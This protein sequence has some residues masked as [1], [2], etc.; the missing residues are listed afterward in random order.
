MASETR[1][2]SFGITIIVPTLTPIHATVRI[3]HGE[4]PKKFNG[5]EFRR[6]QQKML[7]YIT[8]LNLARFIRKDALLLTKNE[9]DQQMV[10]VVE[11]WKHVDFL[12]RNYILNR[13]DNT[14]YN[15]YSPLKMA[16]ELWESF[17]K[18][19]K[20]EDAGMKKFIVGK[21]LEYL[22]VDSETLI[23]QVQEL[24]VIFHDIHA[25]GMILNELVAIIEKLPP[26]WKDF[27]NYLKHKRKEMLFEDLII[28][29]R[30]EED[31]W[32]F[33]KKVGDY[34]IGAS[35]HVVE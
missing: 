26:S 19:Y 12:Y 7:F 21:F 35:A 31:N 24:Q 10:V 32:A 20:A 8:T 17:D 9:A 16:K 25:E 30:I 33:E 29:L 6:W 18:K 23:S 5:A 11:A 2:T 27:K 3:N 28:R 15:V 34:P 22:R 1:N 4:T 14:L 13:L